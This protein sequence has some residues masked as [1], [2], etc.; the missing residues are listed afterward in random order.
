MTTEVQSSTTYTTTIDGVLTVIAIKS[1]SITSKPQET[2]Y[3]YETD[4]DVSHV[5]KTVCDSDNKC[6]LT[7]EVQSSTTY[8][9]TIDG[10]LTVITTAVP[11]SKTE[12][13]SPLHHFC[14]CCYRRIN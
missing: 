1:S 10:V 14:C 2:Q 3:E 6:Y 8:T 11:I 4:V 7:T 12:T 13:S 9:T 5:I